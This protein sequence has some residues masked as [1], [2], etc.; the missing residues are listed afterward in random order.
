MVETTGRA[1]IILAPTQVIINPGRWRSIT[2]TG[3]FRAKEAGWLRFSANFIKGDVSGS[4][5]VA[6]PTLIATVVGK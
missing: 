4:V 1:E 5:K 2:T 3:L 6:G